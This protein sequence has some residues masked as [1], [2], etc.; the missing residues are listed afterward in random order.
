MIPLL[1]ACILKLQGQ[2]MKQM[3]LDA[4]IDNVDLFKQRGMSSPDGN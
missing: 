2:E 4:V 1:N 3:F